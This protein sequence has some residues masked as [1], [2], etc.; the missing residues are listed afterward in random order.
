MNG[1]TFFDQ[2]RKPEIIQTRSERWF[3]S[4]LQYCFFFFFSSDQDVSNCF[5]VSSVFRLGYGNMFSNIVF[6][7][8]YYKNLT[9]GACFLRKEYE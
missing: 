7:A 9:I 3:G 1:N 2:I 6:K 5:E 8:A 4:K